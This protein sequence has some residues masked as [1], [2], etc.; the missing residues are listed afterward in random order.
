MNK[1]LISL[2]LIAL[3]FNVLAQP[4]GNVPP[5]A[6]KG[7]VKGKIVEA[8]SNTPLEYANVVLYS[9]KD[10]SLAGGSIAD[11]NGVFVVDNLKSGKYYLDAKF[12][13][14]EHTIKGDIF[15]NPKNS[16]VNLGV[17]E[18]N[19]AAENLNEV[20]VYAQD[21]PI[22]YEID[23]KIIDP[24]QFPTSANGT[25]TDV[26]ANTPSVVVDIEGNVT[27][28]GSSD[29]T[30]LIDGRPTPF[31]AADALEQIPASTIRNIEI[32]TNPSAKFDPDGNAGIININTKKSK[33]TGISGIVNASADTYGSLTGD[34]LFNYKLDKF[35]FF[36]SGNKANRLGR[37]TLERFNQTFGEDTITTEAFGDNERGHESWSVKSGFDYY[38]NDLNTFTFNVSL[39]GRSRIRSGIN[40]FH[41]YST[42]GMDLRSLTESSTDGGGTN[43]AFSFDY[44]KKFEKEGQELTAYAYYETG[45]D[46]E[47]SFYD[48]FNGDN[49]LIEG[50]KSWEEGD[51]DEMRFKLDYVH[52]FTKKMKLEAGYQS[53]V[54]YAKEWNDVH[55]YTVSNEYVP[56]EKSEFYS[57]TEFDRTIHSAYSTF[58]NSGELLG[59][60]LGLRTEYTDRSLAWKDETYEINRW[61]FFPSAHVSYKLPLEQQLIASYT[62]RIERPR[63]YFLEPFLTYM[64]ANNVRQ[65]NPDIEPEYIDS[66]EVG[67]QKQIGKKGFV[68][69]EMYHRKTNNKIERIRSVYDLE[70]NVMKM[71]MDN[72]GTDYAT[73]FEFMWNYNPTK[74]WSFNLMGNAFNYRVE[75]NL[76]GEDMS[77]TS[78][79][80][81][82]R[83]GNTFTV[84]KNTK[85]QLDAMY[86]SPTT[87]LQGRREGFAFT[88]VAVRQDFFDKK[89]NVTLSVRDVLNTAKFGF[90][91][92]GPGFYSK[93]NFDMASPVFALSLSYKINNYRPKRSQRGEGGG[94]VMGGEGSD[95]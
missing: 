59:F 13:G 22:I 86:H 64:D 94:D 30:V 75:G 27:M 92:E 2:L 43:V 7:I 46:Y 33:L 5:A 89:L 91:S 68:S 39:N 73:G 15:I 74:W 25:A 90:E 53:R 76:Y 38:L 40:N 52:P 41:E 51:G 18:L 78:N 45:K 57:E 69:A 17:L 88:N 3:F 71:T 37:G 83:L 20:N 87:T 14:Y 1:I 58:S 32:I 63:S 65:G 81:H 77:E 35:N 12:I 95:F 54:D 31:K 11:A 55:W 10:S 4:S 62:R 8:G 21:A 16:T 49:I 19:P 23:K 26:L 93:M 9:L 85:L 47:L 44:K 28:R 6:I 79:N 72:V 61:D 82:G 67:Y 60:Q 66:Y 29:F 36:L 70:N 24:A 56:S 80:W 84:T 50:L 34:F 42:S 48:Q